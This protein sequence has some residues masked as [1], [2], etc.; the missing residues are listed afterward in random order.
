MKTIIGL[1]AEN[2]V[3]RH[4]G[5]DVEYANFGTGNNLDNE[6]VLDAFDLF[7]S[8][9][10]IYSLTDQQ[11][12]RFSYS[13]AIARPS[14]KELSFAQIIDPVSDRIF[15]GGLYRYPDWDGKLSETRIDNL[16]I[17]WELFM[18]G[19]QLFSFGAFYKTF[20]KPIELVRIPTQP[21][22]TEY[23]PRNV[24]TDNFMG[25]RSRSGKTLASFLPSWTISASAQILLMCNRSWT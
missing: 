12:L 1:R 17:R 6:K 25:L 15:N 5:R 8:L 20:D 19:N 3:Q 16:D 11:N 13:R 14:F 21:T 2:Y 18:P 22:S 24:G 7:P 23:Q 10:V 4:T 9:N